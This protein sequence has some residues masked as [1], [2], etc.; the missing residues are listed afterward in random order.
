MEKDWDEATYYPKELDYMKW[1]KEYDVKEGD[2]KNGDPIIVRK[3]ITV[4]ENLRDRENSKY[5]RARK[6]KE[7]Q[8]N[9]CQ[10]DKK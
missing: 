6:Y 1:L 5:D 7:K 4:D 9:K 2:D 3:L 8:W 10:D